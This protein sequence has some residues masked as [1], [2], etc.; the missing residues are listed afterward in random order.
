SGQARLLQPV[1]HQRLEQGR[2]SRPGLT[3]SHSDLMDA[4]LGA[5]DPRHLSHQ[6]GGILTGVQVPPT[7]RP[8]IVPAA[9]GPTDWTRRLG[10][11][12]LQVDTHLASDQVQLDVH[13]LQGAFDSEDLLIELSISHGPRLLAS[14]HVGKPLPTSRLPT[15]GGE[16]PLLVLQRLQS[17]PEWA[18]L[19]EKRRMS[20][21][22]ELSYT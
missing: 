8:H 2:K 16:A 6:D 12:V 4:V 20:K 9:G 17:Y 13:N 19:L 14:G 7:A 11:R 21:V 10:L 18:S 1:N 3:P 22:L 15:Q 5:L